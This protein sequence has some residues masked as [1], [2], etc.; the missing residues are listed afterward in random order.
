[1]VLLIVIIL[2]AAAITGSLGGVLEVAAGVVIGLFLFVV[3]IALVGYYAMRRRWRQATRDYQ[4]Y[5]ESYRGPPD[6]YA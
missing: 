5:R 2:V 1:M 6:R 4:Q 3:G